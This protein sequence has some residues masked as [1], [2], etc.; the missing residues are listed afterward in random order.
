MKKNAIYL[1]VAAVIVVAVYGISVVSNKDKNKVVTLPAKEERPVDNTVMKE[2][3]KPV[4]HKPTQT[5]KV[6]KINFYFH[7]EFINFFCF[8]LNNVSF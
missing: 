6:E 3:P 4:T 5:K 8:E 1:C 7:N 2:T